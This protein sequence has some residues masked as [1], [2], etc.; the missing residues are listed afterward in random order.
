MATEFYYRASGAWRKAKEV[1][2]KQAGAWLKGKEIWYRAGGV[3]RKV[4]AG[5]FTSF[6][7]PLSAQG[8]TYTNSADGAASVQ[9]KIKPDGTW[10]VTFDNS[11]VVA[12]GNWGQPTTPG[13]GD[14]NYAQ[15]ELTSTTG[16]SSNTSW[17]STTGWL[18][19]SGTPTA[20]VSALAISAS[21]IRTATYTIRIASD[22]AG[23]NIVSLTTNVT[24]QASAT[25]NPL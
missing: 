21:R 10:E 1:Y 19:V 25:Y 6:V 3:W 12:T 14:S 7:S 2:Y 15:Y 24:L 11:T 23:S 18:P 22:S 8:Q 16:S 20:S 13:A 5:G 4:F 17:T 9:F